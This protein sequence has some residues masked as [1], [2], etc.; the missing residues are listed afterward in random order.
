MRRIRP[1]IHAADNTKCYN[2]SALR[3]ER[4]RAAF[5]AVDSHKS[6]RKRTHTHTCSQ[7]RRSVRCQRRPQT[8]LLGRSMLNR[9][10]STISFFPFRRNMRNIVFGQM[11]SD[12]VLIYIYLAPS[13][14]FRFLVIALIC[15]LYCRW[16]MTPIGSEAHV[17]YTHTHTQSHARN[18]SLHHRHTQLF[19][20]SRSNES[21]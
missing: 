16:L 6:G 13:L 18:T 20:H 8:H 11:R 7:R 2:L 14:C 12:M 1:A 21:E 10:M 15:N 3:W 5:F 19:S 17:R 9:I 4:R